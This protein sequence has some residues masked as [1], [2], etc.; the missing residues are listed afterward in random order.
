MSFV[1]RGKRVWM[2]TIHGHEDTHTQGGTN[3]VLRLYREVVA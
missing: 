3:N 2:E 1:L